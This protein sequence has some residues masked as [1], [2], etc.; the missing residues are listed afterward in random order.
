MHPTGHGRACKV[1]PR[2]VRWWERRLV[3]IVTKRQRLTRGRT[4]ASAVAPEDGEAAV[5]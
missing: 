3:F 4:R 1:Y 2:L 5:G